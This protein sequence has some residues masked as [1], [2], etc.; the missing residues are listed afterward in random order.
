MPSGAGKSEGAAIPAQKSGKPFLFAP[1]TGPSL[2]EKGTGEGIFAFKGGSD[3]AGTV[4]C[5]VCDHE[6]N[7]EGDRFCRNC[8]IM[9]WRRNPGD[10]ATKTEE[11]LSGIFK[12]G[13]IVEQ[14]TRA[15]LFINGALAETLQPG[16]HEVGGLIEKLKHLESYRIAMVVLVDVGD[17]EIA[18]TI[19]DV[20][21]KDPLKL[22]ITCKV[23]IQ[24]SNPSFFFNN[25]M[26]GRDRYLIDE[27]KGSLYDELRNGF[28]EAIGRKSVSELNSDLDLKRQLE[29]SVEN[30]LRTTFQRNGLNLLQ[31]RTLD[32]R[33]QRYDKIRQM[34][35]DAYLLISEDKE[36]LQQRK[37]LFDVYDQ[38]QLQDIFE[39]TREVRYR[40]QRQRLWAEMRSLVNTD[41]MNEIKSADDLE[42]YLHEIDKG[43]LLRE[44]EIKALKNTFG[45]SD[46][47]R[48][49]LLEKIEL[50]Q[51]LEKER[52]DLVGHAQNELA[53]WEVKAK[54]ERQKFDE[55]IRQDE[56]DWDLANKI[57]RDKIETERLRLDGITKLGIEAMIMA[58]SGEQAKVLVELRKTDAMKNM[59]SE[60]ILAI[61]AENSPEVARAFQEKFK[62]LSADVQQKLYDEMKA[63]KENTIKIM[64]AMF[65]KSLETQS[66]AVSG[67]AQ[68]ARIVYPPPG[69]PGFYAMPSTPVSPEV[70]ICPKCREGNAVGK[71]FCGSCGA[72]L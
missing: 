71:K 1:Y 30:H 68:G 15:L 34:Q 35:Q 11:N 29:V 41:K 24:L 63:D 55:K 8:G 58:A 37:G 23:V 14:G 18:F 40:E 38:S 61:A 21:T 25:V 36:K 6:K 43:K 32:Y 57:Q 62:G 70:V 69:Q 22:D 46:L 52:I 66:A 56:K 64:L 44:D 42:S 59:T 49:F 39:E 20:Y 72:A 12:K 65:N 17:I 48:E 3:M 13:I 27:L 60:Q 51:R 4:K 67:V 53:A 7:F 9:I 19:P 10:F 45:Q 54:I 50:E 5:I 16:L 28:N 2:H 33:F 26:K 31:L 47:Q